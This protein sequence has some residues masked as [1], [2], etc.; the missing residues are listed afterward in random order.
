VLAQ[1][2]CAAVADDLS[3]AGVPVQ[4]GSSLGAMRWHKLV[5]NMAFSGLC[6]LS[7]RRTQ[8]LLADASLR[9]RLLTVMQEVVAAAAADGVSL[10]PDVIAEF[11][12]KTES[13]P[14]YAPSMQLDAEAGRPLELEAIYRVPLQRARH[15]GVAMPEA[16]RLLLD[17]EALG[18]AAELG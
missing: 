16:T 7:G 2:T 13:M 1:T 5:W 11:L 15:N 14:S 12:N 6:T 8:A 9:Q 18:T 4:I 3:A 10:A 17:L